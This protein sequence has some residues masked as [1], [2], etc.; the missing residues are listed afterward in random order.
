MQVDPWQVSWGSPLQK[1]VSILNLL[2]CFN[3]EAALAALLL[4]RP[5]FLVELSWRWE[6]ANVFVLFDLAQVK[7]LDCLGFLSGINLALVWAYAPCL[8]DKV[9]RRNTRRRRISGPGWS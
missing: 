3:P 4:Q 1:S 7:L 9:L 2:T 5:K 6:F 8:V